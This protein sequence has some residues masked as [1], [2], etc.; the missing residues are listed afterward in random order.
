MKID[1]GQ[2]A[3]V[4][5]L[6]RLEL[7]ETE[8]NEFSRQLSDIISYVEKINELDTDSVKPS[9]HVVDINNVFRGDKA[10]NSL[11]RKDIEAIAPDFKGGYFIV[12]RILEEIE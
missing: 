9:D 11:D 5:R 6:A 10:S 4:S 12:P 3:K 2:I 7:T 8:K 1:S